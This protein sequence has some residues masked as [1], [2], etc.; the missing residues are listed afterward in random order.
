M[1]DYLVDVPV[2][3]LFFSRPEQFNKVF[4]Q[5][6]KARPSKLFLYQDGPREGRLDDKKGIEECRRIAE[7]IDWAC[8]VKRLYQD[9]NYGCDPSEYIA[10]KWAF[11]YVDKC[12]VLEDDDVPSVS[13]FEFCKEMLDKYE[14]DTRI[15]LISGF[16]HEEVTN[17]INEDYFFTSN[18][19]IWGWASWK[20]VIDQW[21]NGYS[22]LNDKNTLD[23]LGE[24]ISARKYIGNFVEMCKEHK[25]SGKEHYESILIANHWLNNY[26]SI[27]PQK[28]MIKNI[29][30]TAD[31][32]HFNGNIKCQPKGLR[33]IFTMEKYE[34]AGEIN[35]PK[36]VNEHFAY[37]QRVYRIMGWGHPFVKAYRFIEET[38]YIL[39]Y[40]NPKDAVSNLKK[41]IKKLNEGQTY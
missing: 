36:Y 5:V 3:L 26:L 30:A 17:D 12:I 7:N 24:I 20:R 4:E 15:G 28:N 23:R 19:S 11:S 39:I 40:G 6:R 34:L 22:F 8:D 13:F 25:K 10:Q 31:S 16:N 35:H 14:N 33:R 1:K 37:K 29:G 21:D 9:K 18:V 27:V 38:I 41:K 32:T 2:L